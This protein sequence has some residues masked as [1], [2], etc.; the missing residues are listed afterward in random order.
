M[1]FSAAVLVCALALLPTL[2]ALPTS[3]NPSLIISLNTQEDT[4]GFCWMTMYKE[5]AF[6]GPPLRIA[7]Q[8]NGC[9]DLSIS[10]KNFPDDYRTGVKSM[11]IEAKCV[12]RV[13][14]STMTEKRME[15]NEREVEQAAA[16]EMGGVGA[17]DCGEDA[18]YM[19]WAIGRKELRGRLAILSCNGPPSHG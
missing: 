14:Y 1:H 4:P 8:E 13:A 18:E 12:C 6:Q 7:F 15:T 5:A 11:D 2:H 17:T 3:P 9:Y 16:G 19:D 10:H